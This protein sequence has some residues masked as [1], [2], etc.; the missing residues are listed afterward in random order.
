MFVTQMS[1]MLSMALYGLC[2]KK[3]AG[4]EKELETHFLANKGFGTL[5]IFFNIVASYLSGWVVTGVP[6]DAGALGHVIWMWIPACSVCGSIFNVLWPRLRR[7][8]EFTK[9][10]RLQ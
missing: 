5:V 8:G 7:I 4:A 10:V 3:K 6:N 1:G 9:R 2:Q